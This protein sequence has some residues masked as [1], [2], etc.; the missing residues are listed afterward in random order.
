MDN[1]RPTPNQLKYFWI[2][3]T[4]YIVLMIYGLRELHSYLVVQ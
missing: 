4:I 2:G 3:F 1:K